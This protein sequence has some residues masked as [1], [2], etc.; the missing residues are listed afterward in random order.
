MITSTLGT[1]AFTGTAD[2][3]RQDASVKGDDAFARQGSSQSK[4]AINVVEHLL[5]GQ[6]EGK[7]RQARNSG[8]TPERFKDLIGDRPYDLLKHIDGES[9]APP[10]PSAVPAGSVYSPSRKMWKTP[11]GALFDANGKPV[12]Q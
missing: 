4:D 9:S 2:H 5:A 11:G 7:E 6:L 12:G 10:R 8:V 1:S 3:H